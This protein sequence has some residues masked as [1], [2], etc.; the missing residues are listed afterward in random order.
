MSVQIS[1]HASALE[2]FL[3]K[4]SLDRKVNICDGHFS[5]YILCRIN[6]NGKEQRPFTDNEM[7]KILMDYNYFRNYFSRKGLWILF[8]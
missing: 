4:L 1:K 7:K 5:D 6:L 3:I 8:D 2:D